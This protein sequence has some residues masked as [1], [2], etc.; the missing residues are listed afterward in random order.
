MPD[1]A[2]ILQQ[3]SSGLKPGQNGEIDMNNMLDTV[4]KTVSTMTGNKGNEKELK[5]MA[6]SMMNVL[7][8]MTEQMQVQN[9]V[10]VV[11]GSKVDINIGQSQT[12]LRV[13]VQE[14]NYEEI[15]S[16]DEVDVFKPR[17][18]DMEI[19]IEVCL[20]DLYNGQEKKIAINRNRIHKDPKTKKDSIVE[21]RKKIVIPIE[22]GSRDEQKIIYNKQSS[23]LPGY[24]TGDI[25]INLKE[26]AHSFFEREKNNLFVVKKISLFESYAA[27]AG[28]INLT[29]RTLDNRFLI[30]DAGSVP[31]HAND[32]LRKI[33][34]EG[35]PVYKENGLKGDL[36]IRFN[37]VLPEKIEDISYLRN[38]F[39]AIDED[40]IYNDGTK[41]SF[42]I[43]GRKITKCIL[44]KVTEKDLEELDY[45]SDSD[46]SDDSDSDDESDDDSDND[47]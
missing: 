22:P 30:L 3:L 25:I 42:D 24:E 1:F 6:K 10:P 32:G 43:K 38:I 17:T 47:S 14:K 28:I 36:Y 46:D 9:P 5:N 7:G 35:M 15:E 39:P 40:I 41:G 2:N 33:R 37:L 21:E 16:D 18:K 27:A 4:V 29:I 8:P 44:E 12:Q 11:P 31:L 45:R 20:E 26:V 23:E 19:S 13:P 34:G